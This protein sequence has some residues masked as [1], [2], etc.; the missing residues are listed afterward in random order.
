M[1][2]GDELTAI[3]KELAEWEQYCAD[4]SNAYHTASQATLALNTKLVVAGIGLAAVTT[5]LSGTGGVAAGVSVTSLWY[6]GLL[7]AGV[8]VLTTAVTGLQK[9][10]FASPEQAKQYH[11]AAAG[12]GSVQRDIESAMTGTVLDDI[13]TKRDAIG[14]QLKDLDSQAPELALKQR[15]SS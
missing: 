7:G 13:K 2:N 1:S 12:Y 4:W 5:L 6:F 9:L 11:S 8:G 14:A 10:P 15:P 3:K